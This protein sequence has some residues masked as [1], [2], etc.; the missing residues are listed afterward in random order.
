MNFHS[1]RE[2][3][4]IIPIDIRDFG[5][6]ADERVNTNEIQAAVDAAAA[7]GG[8][9]V[10][11]PQGVWLCG[12]IWL[13]SNVELHLSQGATL[14]GTN[15]PEDYPYRSPMDEGLVVSRRVGPRR[16][17]G[18]WDAENVAVTGGGTIDGRGGCG[19]Q[20]QGKEGAEGH[21]QNL[22]FVKCRDVVVRDVHLKD[23]GSWMQVYMAC[24]K[25]LVSGIRVWNHPGFSTND[26]MDIDGCNDMRISDIDVDSHDD[27]LVFK[28]T[29]PQG[30]RNIVV[31]NCRLRSACHG[32]KFGTESVG[33]YE[34]IRISNCIVSSTRDVV[35]MDGY[36]EG[37]PVITGVAMECT[38]GGKMR[39]VHVDGLIVD[40][41]FCPIFI[42]LGNR[43]DR[44]IE[45]ETD[46][47]E[48]CIENVSVKNVEARSVG[49][50]SSSISGYP[51][52]PVRNVHLQNIH[53]SYE[54][55]GT[56]DKVLPEVADKHNGYPEV[57]MWTGKTD[58]TLPSYAFYLR[59][60]EQV[61]FENLRFD[62]RSPDEREAIVVAD[63]VSGFE[64]H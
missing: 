31:T 34:N 59:H 60:A 11:V 38:D 7:E 9:Q 3:D 51:G 14:A 52:N 25:V 36:P 1:R 13:K 23:A 43:H 18:A 45:G 40:N 24:E 39:N 42:K 64:T 20:I 44:R 21:P 15:N 32:I 58:K 37:R 6:V 46:F 61:R 4:L 17:V 30:C 8:G 56:L 54:G 63:N 47:S 35:P 62:L 53:V 57:N 2:K 41:V 19:G 55:G 22:Q 33:G 16:F 26:G 28:S 50:L 27:A 49:K 12:T 48:G 10:I 5:A 29:G